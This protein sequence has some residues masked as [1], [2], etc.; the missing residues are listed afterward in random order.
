M[1]YTI[2][3]F[4]SIRTRMLRDMRNLDPAAHTDADSDNYIR[5]TGT[6]SAAEGLYDHQAW[7][8]RQIIPDTADPEYL[9]Q[10]CALRGITRRAATKATGTITVT[11]RPG[12]IVPAY[13]Q[14]KDADGTVYQTT[15]AVTLTGTG[16]AVTASAPC[17]AAQAGAL[18]DVVGMQ[19]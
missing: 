18:P 15:A 4:D 12:S 5:A 9:E 13:T 3:S 16:E 7:I 17:E 11:G 14:A 8:V 19:V 1:P 10:H 2:P 6:A